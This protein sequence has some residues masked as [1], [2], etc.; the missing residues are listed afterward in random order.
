MHPLMAIDKTGM[1][2]SVR[3]RKNKVEVDGAGDALA[4]AETIEE[5]S[6]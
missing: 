3:S 4:E 6:G 1:E 5:D 2:S